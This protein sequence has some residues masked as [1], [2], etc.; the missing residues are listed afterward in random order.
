MSKGGEGVL[1]CNCTDKCKWDSYVLLQGGDTIH[2]S[3]VMSYQIT[4]MYR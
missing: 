1:N 4:I 3:P 2:I